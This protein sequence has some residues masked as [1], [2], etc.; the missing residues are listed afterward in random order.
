VLLSFDGIYLLLF[1]HYCVVAGL[2]TVDSFPI[3]G[4][5]TGI[6]LQLAS[7]GSKSRYVFGQTLAHLMIQVY[8][9][10]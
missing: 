5:V 2:D 4:A 1:L 10:A 3:L 7:T 6:L 9:S 8:V